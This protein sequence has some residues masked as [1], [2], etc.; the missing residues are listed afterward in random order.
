MT[1]AFEQWKNKQPVSQ[2]YAF[3]VF[4]MSCSVVLLA[5][6]ANMAPCD[7]IAPLDDCSDGGADCT[8]EAETADVLLARQLTISTANSEMSTGGAVVAGDMEHVFQGL[9]TRSAEGLEDVPQ[10]TLVILTSV[11]AEMDKIIANAATLTE[12]IQGTVNRAATDI[13]DC[14]ADAGNISTLTGTVSSKR[15]THSACRAQ[16]KTH[17]A[18]KTQKCADL[19][20]YRTSLQA[21]SCLECS[22]SEVVTGFENEN[23]ECLHQLGSWYATTNSTW[24]SKKVLCDSFIADH[25]R[26][27]AT[28][29]SDQAAFES[30][31]CIY[32]EAL[33]LTCNTQ[34]TCRSNKITERNTTL[35]EA[36]VSEASSKSEMVSATKVKCFINVLRADTAQQTMMSNCL[37]LTPNT[38]HLDVTY[39]PIPSATAC[40]LS[41]VA[42][43]PCDSAWKTAEYE[44]KDWYN[45]A[46]PQTCTPCTTPTTTPAPTVVPT[47]AT[48]I[49][50][51]V[52][53]E[54]PS[55]PGAP[56]FA[57][58]NI[59][60]D[61]LDQWS[62]PTTWFGPDRQGSQYAGGGDPRFYFILDLGTPHMVGELQIV[63]L[64]GAYMCVAIEISMSDDGADFGGVT[65]WTLQEDKETTQKVP[66]G[67]QGR[68]LKVKILTYG[69]YS[70]GLTRVKVVGNAVPQAI[71]TTTIAAALTPAPTP[72]EA[73]WV[74]TYA[75]EECNSY[76]H[77]G[78]NSDYKTIDECAALIWADSTCNP[79]VLVASKSG[80]AAKPASDCWCI[81]DDC[82][83]RTE[84]G[85]YDVYCRNNCQEA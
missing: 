7:A 17:K 35:A 50:Y 65:S 37:A 26:T 64:V 1:G 29:T 82:Q 75:N 41:L 83:S 13:T 79:N 6:L 12:T 69:S 19:E 58:S 70:A 28:C 38:S 9:A 24:T 44:N 77:I 60:S 3:N 27:Q 2:K 72:A 63:N 4:R 61:D 23:M 42:T 57:F 15:S 34:T 39:P 73:S 62:N 66:V 45:D 47:E 33:T 21:P 16:E 18:G 43:K 22:D 51:S 49:D 80:N 74:L 40:D 25:I 85:S 55:Y 52:S 56:E 32:E 54:P 30:V 67:L 76:K 53:H 84:A 36:R 31:F 8:K 78:E 48:S 46:P 81:L 20:S 68:F 14:N 10:A 5:T 71:S 11:D 59:M